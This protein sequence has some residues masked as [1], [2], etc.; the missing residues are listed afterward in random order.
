MSDDL[1]KARIDLAYNR[2]KVRAGFDFAEWTDD[3]RVLLYAQFANDFA[4]DAI[5]MLDEALAQVDRLAQ[6][7]A[8]SDPHADATEDWEMEIWSC[9]GVEAHIFHDFDM[10]E[11]HAPD[12]IYVWAVE[13]AAKAERGKTNERKR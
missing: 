2:G 6:A 5:E 13:H 1:N 9:C 11:I 3:E 10:A 4:D 12:C 7:L 8:N